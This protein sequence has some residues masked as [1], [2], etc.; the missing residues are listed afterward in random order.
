MSSYRLLD[1]TT[2]PLLNAVAVSGTSTYTAGPIDCTSYET[3]TF[4]AEWTGTPTGTIT[5]LGS[6]DGVNYRTFG[7]S[8]GSQPSGTVSGVLIPLFGHGMK[9]LELQ[10]TN[11]TGSG[12]LTV[13]AMGKTR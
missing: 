8:V 5:V 2:N 10:Y 6:L 13:T 9:W 11:Q 12:T 7:V 4:H 3:V 1:R